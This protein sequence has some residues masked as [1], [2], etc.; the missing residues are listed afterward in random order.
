MDAVS[1]D[2]GIRQPA[3]V[4]WLRLAR[5]YH[6]VDR[7]TAEHVRQHGLTVA[8]FDLLA[9]V[10]AHE[11]CSQQDVA[12]ALLVTKGN[13]VQLLD[14]MEQRGLISR[15]P[16]PT[17]RG[18]RLFLTDLG[19]DLRDRVVPAQE[20]LISGTFGDMPR[21]D[22]EALARILR[23]LERGLGQGTSTKGESS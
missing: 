21:A 19:R 1:G 18:N 7:L 2:P 5:V 11:G 16:N 10:G 8:Q 4:A 3:L 17:A 20:A 9:Q 14:R 15:Q 22:T 13:I 12:K 6:R 23:T